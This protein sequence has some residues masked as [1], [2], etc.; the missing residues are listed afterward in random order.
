MFDRIELGTYLIASALL[1]YKVSFLKVEPKII[2][3]E[4]DILKKMG[5]K[6]CMCLI[7]SNKCA[8]VKIKNKGMHIAVPK[9]VP[10]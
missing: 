3:T 4:I 5:I 2:K 6:N 1:G 8:L 10:K 9:N 7:S